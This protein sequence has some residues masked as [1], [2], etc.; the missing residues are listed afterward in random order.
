M[1]RTPFCDDQQLVREPPT[2]VSVDRGNG[3]LVGVTQRGARGP[4]LGLACPAATARPPDRA[5]D[6]S[7][8]RADEIS[9]TIPVQR[10][11]DIVPETYV[12]NPAPEDL[13]SS[14]LA[15]VGDVELATPVY[16]AQHLAV[17][18]MLVGPEVQH[19][20]LVFGCPFSCWSDEG[21]K[22]ELREALRGLHRFTLNGSAATSTSLPI[23][24]HNRLWPPRI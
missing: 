7:Q 19:I 22:T 3:S 24:C 14:D 12:L 21:L 18:G 23:Y 9:I 15:S 16:V 10:R 13:A 11:G 8:R 20:E 6:E 17:I 1:Y 4:L 5:Y 2:L